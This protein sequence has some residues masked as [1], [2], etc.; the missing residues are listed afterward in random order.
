MKVFA[1]HQHESATGIHV[2]PAFLNP[3]HLP[4]HTT[5]SGSLKDSLRDLPFGH[6][7]ILKDLSILGLMVLPEASIL[8]KQPIFKI[9]VLCFDTHF[10]SNHFFLEVL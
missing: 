4:P 10:P 7:G 1:I 6:Y 2:F 5:F 3:P 8:A 9:S